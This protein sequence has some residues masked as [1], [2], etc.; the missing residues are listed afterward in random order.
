MLCYLLKG[1]NSPCIGPVI[2]GLNGRFMG[3]NGGPRFRNIQILGTRGLLP[4]CLVML[5]G[6]PAQQRLARPLSLVIIVARLG[7]IKGIVGN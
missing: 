4:W 1:L 3:V 7:I 5:S 2:M 6:L